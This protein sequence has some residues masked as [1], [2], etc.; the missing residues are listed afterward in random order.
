M[1]PHLQCWCKKKGSSDTGGDQ[2]HQQQ[3][4]GHTPNGPWFCFSPWG[5]SSGQCSGSSTGGVGWHG[6]GLLGSAPQ[7]AYTVFTPIQ[8]SMPYQQ[9]FQ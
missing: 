3:T 6:Q 9:S 7:Q 2:Q 1:Q 5:P 4:R 8:Y